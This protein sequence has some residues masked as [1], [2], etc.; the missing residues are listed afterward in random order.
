[1]NYKELLVLSYFKNHYK[2]Y[3]FAELMQLM[4]MT[5]YELDKI[6]DLLLERK[7]LIIHNHCLALSKS[8]EDLLEEEKIPLIGKNI[9]D[10]KKRKQMSLKEVYIPMDFKL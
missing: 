3:D 6:L 9:I 5:A 7:L 10:N 4:G 1:M 8:A 2:K